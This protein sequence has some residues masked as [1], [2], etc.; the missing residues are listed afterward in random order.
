MKKLIITLLIGLSGLNLAKAQT[1][2][3]FSVRYLV[4]YEETTKRYTAWVVPDYDTPNVNNGA[5][6]ETGITAQVTLKVPR[7]FVLT[8]IQDAK[9]TWDKKPTKLG[10]QPIFASIGADPTAAY[11]V[12]G[13]TPTPTNFGEF[14][15]GEPVS[16]FSFRSQD[17]TKAAVSILE[18]NDPFVD[19][20]NKH[21]ALNVGSSFYSQSGQSMKATAK[22]LEQF[23]RGTQMTDVLANMSKKLNGLSHDAIATEAVGNFQVLAYPNPV[24]TNLTVT[25]FSSQEGANVRLDLVDLQG[26]TQQSIQ[27]KAKAGF[28]TTQVPMTQ[29]TSV[30]YLLQTSSNGQVVTQRILKQ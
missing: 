7:D 15:Q 30:M 18:S 20:A 17:Q 1:R 22:P 29:L 25:Y 27:Q 16:M 6:E 4:T 3:D 12:I 5:T 19:L 10:T 11:Y 28:N 26:V 21:L 24:K 13:K 9:G 8:D 23:A 14:K 2:S